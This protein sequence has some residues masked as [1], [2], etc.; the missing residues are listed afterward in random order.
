[1]ECFI[2]YSRVFAVGQNAFQQPQIVSP[3]PI[4]EEKKKGSDLKTSVAPAK[5]MSHRN[6][7]SAIERVTPNPSQ[8]SMIVNPP[9]VLLKLEE[10]DR[11]PS[12]MPLILVDRAGNPL[13]VV[14]SLKE[15]RNKLTR[16]QLESTFVYLTGD[17][18][19]IR[20]FRRA[21]K[22]KQLKTKAKVSG[23]P[24]QKRSE[25]TVSQAEPSY[26]KPA[27]AKQQKIKT[28]RRS[29]G[30]TGK[31]SKPAVAK[32]A[33][34]PGRSPVQSEKTSKTPAESGKELAQ[35]TVQSNK[36]KTLDKQPIKSGRTPEDSILQKSKTLELLRRRIK[37]Y[38]DVE[39][40]EPPA[41]TKK[42]VKPGSS[43][44]KTPEKPIEKV[45]E[46]TIAK[47]TAQKRQ[48]AKKRPHKQQAKTVKDVAIK[49]DTIA[50]ETVKKVTETEASAKSD[51]DRQ[52]ETSKKKIEPE[53]PSAKKSDKE[54]APGDRSFVVKTEEVNKGSVIYG[55][56][57]FDSGLHI[58]AATDLQSMYV[59]PGESFTIS[60]QITNISGRPGHFVEEFDMPEGF[61]L[62]FPPA[63]FSL[64]PMETYNSIVMVTVPQ[65]L[66]AGEH[67]F[68][69]N[70]F[71]RNDQAIHGSF[72]F[73]FNIMEMLDLN[74]VI[75]EKPGSVI[76][77]EDFTIKGKLFNNSNT[78]LSLGIEASE[79]K[80]FR[81]DLSQ[82]KAD[83]APGEFVDLVIKG[84]T[85]VGNQPGHSLV[86]YLTVRDLSKSQKPVLLKQII[87]FKF[88]TKAGTKTDFKHRLPVDATV[89]VKSFRGEYST[90]MEVSS[91]GYL[92][93]SHSRKIEFL[94]RDKGSNRDSG[95]SYS[96]ETSSLLYNDRKMKV[97]IG[98]HSFGVAAL[99]RSYT[100][101]GIG[102]DY[103]LTNETEVGFINYETRYRI[104]ELEGKGAFV[105]QSFGRKLNLKLSHFVSTSKTNKLSP[106]ERFTTLAFKFRPNRI[107]RLTGEVGKKWGGDLAD[108][109]DAAFKLNYVTKVRSYATFSVS[110]SDT[111]VIYAGSNSGNEN[112]RTS[113]SIP[114]GKNIKSFVS[115][116]K[117]KQHRLVESDST[118]ASQND[119]MRT[120]VSYRLNKDTYFRLNYSDSHR[121]DRISNE[122]NTKTKAYTG[123]VTKN[124]RRYSSN[125]SFS[126]RVLDDLIDGT[127]KD[128]IQHRFNG[129]YK[130]TRK[131]MLNA[132]GSMEKNN[133]SNDYFQDNS[134]SLGMGINFRVTNAL[135]AIFNFRQTN[136]SETDRTSQNMNLNLNYKKSN[137]RVNF[138]MSKNSYSTVYAEAPV[139]Y[140]LSLTREFGMPT[141]R[142]NQIGALKGQVKEIV[143]S[144]TRSLD[145]ITLLMKNMAAVTNSDGNFVFA[146]LTP[147]TYTLDIDRRNSGLNKISQ[148]GLPLKV[149]IPGGKVASVTLL[150]E[151][152]CT[153]SG[154]IKVASTEIP[155]DT[156]QIK[157]EAGK[158]ILAPM[159][160]G[161]RKIEAQK[162]AGVILEVRS[163]KRRY[164]AVSDSEGKFKFYGLPAGSWKYRVYENTIPKGYRISPEKGFIN[165]KPEAENKLTFNVSPIIRKVEMVEAE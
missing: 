1:M 90:Q 3:P 14:N 46:P 35:E 18:S 85:G 165:V 61:Q 70:V 130:I 27:Q 23:K 143:G 20:K 96:R 128:R 44:L 9:P 57:S 48:K 80:H 62:A 26:K 79:Q 12:G 88:F 140:Q 134:N 87:T 19:V 161:F 95:L 47:K 153:F 116:S 145:N 162:L 150:L 33:E 82:E 54:V 113:V 42:P 123:S 4:Y 73:K 67:T 31:I 59:E 126:K 36:T 94:V 78:K 16:E 81:L 2:S 129:S 56:N 64:E 84:T 99:S 151:E 120:G 148:Q 146:D 60:F 29:P 158:D 144:Q 112:T 138:R 118:P 86:T 156:V 119:S 49:K 104:N 39:S 108:T 43:E 7:K 45:I 136:Y 13:A 71:E 77:G 32:K 63:E 127:Q 25:K 115:Y 72:S 40:S 5:K 93:D 97:A 37:G 51:A 107:S 74:F 91:E 131:L 66:K 105:S 58:E 132:Y 122:Y 11:A 68:A 149:Y 65:Y 21:L 102:V 22:N 110:H 103:N 117:S 106:E 141:G 76:Y 98:D 92:D 164:T 109:R 142:N 155:D 50:E 55:V 34:A 28:P 8:K 133:S 135:T 137:N 6:E 15:I 101:R 30:G 124:G 159:P 152:G 89:R 139:Y 69:Y 111:G 157:D 38:S 53:K 10:A 75:E 160:A 163:N 121:F 147:G 114:L 125:Y 83:L 17:P 24:L 52:K 41:E 100:G 154:Q